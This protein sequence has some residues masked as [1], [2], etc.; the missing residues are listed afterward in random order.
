MARLG[1][2]R[3]SSASQ[4]TDLQVSALKAA[5]CDI[6]RSEKMSGASRN[7]GEELETLLRFIRKGDELCVTR[8]DR[9]ARSVA[10]LQDIVRELQSKGAFLVATE[11][12]MVN[13][14]SNEGRLFLGLLS[15]F[16][17][18]ENSIRK[19]RQL[20]GI[21]AAKAKGIYKGRKPSIDRAELLR[22]RKRGM[23]ATVIADKM[24]ISRASVY[25]LL[26]ETRK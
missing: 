25:R 2:A 17:E 16:S 6:I 5:G 21:E 10:D 7:G 22:L 1:Y 9:V 20:A 19:D 4:S 12:P 18:F 24:G 11:Q 8:I 15:L 13:M 14:K 3:A 23:G 26:N